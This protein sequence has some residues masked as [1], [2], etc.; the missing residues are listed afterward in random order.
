MLFA[1]LQAALEN[2]DAFL[3]VCFNFYDTVGKGGVGVC[4]REVSILQ[5]DDSHKPYKWSC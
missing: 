4:V 1:N 2:T 3:V 5:L